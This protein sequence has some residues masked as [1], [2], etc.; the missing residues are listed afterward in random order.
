MHPSNKLS[1]TESGSIKSKYK[2]RW[3]GASADSRMEKADEKA[4]NLFVREMFSSY[5][6]NNSRRNKIRLKDY[7]HTIYILNT[8]TYIYI[9]KETS[10]VPSIRESNL[11]TEI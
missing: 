11:P 2:N 4:L 5:E 10:I 9:R 7:A 3:L 8:Y 1:L 6:Y